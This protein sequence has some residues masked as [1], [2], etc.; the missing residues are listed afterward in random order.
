MENTKPD[1][2]DY[3]KIKK[4]AKYLVVVS[5]LTQKE[6]SKILGVSEKTLSHWATKGEWRKDMKEN[7]GK[8][9]NIKSFLGRFFTYVFNAEPKIAHIIKK[10]WDSFLKKEETNIEL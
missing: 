4:R 8:E 6:V 1:S 3:I 7:F 9:E 5:G 2:I 10:Y